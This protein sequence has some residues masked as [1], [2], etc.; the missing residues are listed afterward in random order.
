MDPQAGSL[1]LGDLWSQVLTLLAEPT[2]NL[3]AALL[4]YG[5]I[6]LLLLIVVIVALIFLVSGPEDV[7][8]EDVPDT[9]LEGLPEAGAAP[10]H[11]APARAAEMTTPPRSRLMSLVIVLGIIAGVWVAAGVSTSLSPVCDGCHVITPHNERDESRTD[12]HERVA[13]V[14]CHESGGVVARYTTALPARVLHIVDAV[15][16]SRSVQGY[17]EVASRAC[18]SCH[19]R[20]VRGLVTD[21]D[22]GILMSHS[23]PLEATMRCLDCHTPVD[24]V[25]GDH[26]AGMNPCL[27]CHDAETAPAECETCHDR[28]TAAAARA[29]SATFAKQ[30]VEEISC[31]GCHDEAAECDSC[32]GL[33]MPHTNRFKA[34][35]HARAGAVDFWYNDGRTCAKCHTAER[36]PCRRC[37]GDILGNGHDASLARTHQDAPEETCDRCHQ[38]WQF[39]RGR[40]FCVDLCH[41]PAAIEQ[42]PR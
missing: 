17:G 27:R 33:R 2:S 4:L 34:Y 19:G 14:S 21:E 6:T 16:D 7:E 29:R 8:E 30:Q 25:V 36:R 42:S 40:D 12:P 26:N 31:G 35:A 10:R 5:I 38:T 18:R 32:H 11:A 37:H 23:E 22:R 28:D 13:C 20:A 9:D 15:A 1:D 39:A 41:T 3:Q 24:G